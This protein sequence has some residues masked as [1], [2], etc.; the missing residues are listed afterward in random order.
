VW[1]GLSSVVIGFWC[2]ITVVLVLNVLVLSFKPS[3]EIFSHPW[4][5]PGTLK[6][7][8]YAQLFHDGFMRYYLNSV[9]VLVFAIFFVLVLSAPAAYGLGKFTF[10]GNKLLRTY[11]LIGMMFPAQLGIIPLFNLMRTL[12]LLNTLWGVI[13]VFSVSVS[14]P[15]YFLTNFIQGIPD[16]LREAAWIDG[17]SE[18]RIFLR[19]FVP[20]MKSALAALLP[21]S[22][23]GIW[24][25]FFLP[26]ILLSSDKFKTL[27]LG[28]MKYFSGKG[29]DLSKIGIEFAAMAIT[30]FPLLL[31]YAIGSKNVIG[32]L[33][34]G[35]L[36]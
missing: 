18:L 2:L 20:M 28:L 4:S 10:K 11:F 9:F 27:P 31:L 36:K 25:E 7:V 24:N 13:L 35:A 5:I 33:T 12:H 1:Y 6:L 30:I 32:G 14:V 26:L 29:F 15:I 8:N 21:L 19:I 3:I 23:V 34:Q 17:A 16:A 22:A